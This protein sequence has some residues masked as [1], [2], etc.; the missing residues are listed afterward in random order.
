MAD[1]VN[2]QSVGLK[3]LSSINKNNSY[4]IRLVDGAFGI[5]NRLCSMGIMVGVRITVLENSGYGPVIVKVMGSQLALGRTIAGK[6]FV[7]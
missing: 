1:G 6:I 2:I 7:R 4:N 3:S 5:K